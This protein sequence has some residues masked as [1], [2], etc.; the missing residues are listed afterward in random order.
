MKKKDRLV[1]WTTGGKYEVW[2]RPN[3]TTYCVEISY[4]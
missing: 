3:G 2:E 1:G 4:K